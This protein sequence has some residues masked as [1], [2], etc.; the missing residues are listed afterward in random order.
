MNNLSSFYK[1][2]VM[3]YKKSAHLSISK[4]RETGTF[5]FIFLMKIRKKI[6]IVIN[7]KLICDKMVTRFMEIGERG[8]KLKKVLS[9]L[10]PMLF[11]F[12]LLSVNLFQPTRGDFI[13]VGVI[14]ILSGAVIGFAGNIGCTILKLVKNKVE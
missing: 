9:Y 13:A 10:I 7:R 12:G 1:Q 4:E 5:F 11:M 8:A 14:S 6:K 3:F 2:Q